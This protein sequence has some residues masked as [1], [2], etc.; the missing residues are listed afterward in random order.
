[1]QRSCR[2]SAYKMKRLSG[3]GNIP[4]MPFRIILKDCAVASR[5]SF[6]FG[7]RVVCTQTEIFSANQ[8]PKMR[9]SQQKFFGLRLVSRIFEETL[10]SRNPNQNSATLQ[11]IFH[12][13]KVRQP[14]RRK[15]SIQTVCRRSRR[16][17]A[18]LY[19][20]ARNF[21]LFSNIQDQN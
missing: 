7:T 18:F 11:V 13:I 6:L 4:V 19:L 20:A 21:E 15:D 17:E 10:T 12:Q 5:S 3:K 16:L 9:E 14:I 1:M 8:S 2:T